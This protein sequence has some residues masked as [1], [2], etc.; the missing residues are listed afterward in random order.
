MMYV[1]ERKIIATVYEDVEKTVTR[2]MTFTFKTCDTTIDKCRK[3]LNN[4]VKKYADNP[5]VA[6]VTPI[7]EYFEN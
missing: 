6:K 7:S 4:Q 3:N 5:Y 1:G 2:E